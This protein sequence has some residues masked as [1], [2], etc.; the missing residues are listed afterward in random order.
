[1]H[2]EGN[3]LD[4]AEVELILGESEGGR[5]G[6]GK[7]DA[8]VD[9]DADDADDNGLVWKE[10][11]WLLINPMGVPTEREVQTTER[12]AHVYRCMLVRNNKLWQR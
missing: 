5:Q 3:C 1:V 11:G 12:G 9:D 4:V 6:G 7:D 8:A 2:C 10:G